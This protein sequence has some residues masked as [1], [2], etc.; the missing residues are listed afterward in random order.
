M[1]M[2]SEA[3]LLVP[4]WRRRYLAMES[5]GAH[6]VHDLLTELDSTAVHLP[7]VVDGAPENMLI[8]ADE[9]DRDARRRPAWLGGSSNA[10]PAS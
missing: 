6:R 1:T 8:R 9:E 4:D 2:M 5:R 7:G 3:D 10:S